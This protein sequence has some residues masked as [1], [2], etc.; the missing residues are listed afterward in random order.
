MSS[1][2]IV[3][4]LLL[5]AA[6]TALYRAGQRAAPY[7]TP[8]ANGEPIQYTK[9]GRIRQGIGAVGS[10]MV[11]GFVRS[12]V[13]TSNQDL[14]GMKTALRTK[15]GI[16]GTHARNN[17]KLVEQL[18]SAALDALLHAHPIAAVNQAMRARN[19]VSVVKHALT[20]P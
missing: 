12:L 9:I 4:L 15:P 13:D 7:D 10:M 14:A 3:L 18:D 2:K 19:Y 6:G 16:D 5:G 17:A 20:D 1:K 8:T 11:G